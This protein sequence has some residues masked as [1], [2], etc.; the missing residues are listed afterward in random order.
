MC[1]RAYLRGQ[2]EYVVVVRGDPYVAPTGTG[3]HSLGYMY[4]HSTK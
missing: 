2:T 4:V 1:L 3:H